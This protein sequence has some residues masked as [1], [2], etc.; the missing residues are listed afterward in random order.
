M[1]KF[2]RSRQTGRLALQLFRL[3]RALEA[4]R[5]NDDGANIADQH[6]GDNGIGNHQAFHLNPLLGRAAKPTRR[7]SVPAARAK[8]ASTRTIP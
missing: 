6:D 8:R 1:Q 5:A 3:P 2:G 7:V 4:A